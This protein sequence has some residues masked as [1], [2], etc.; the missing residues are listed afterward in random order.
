MH[1]LNDSIAPFRARVMAILPR[2]VV[3]SFLA[4]TGAD[5]DLFG[6][7]TFGREIVHAFN[8]HR[9][10]PY[11][12]TSDISWVNHEW[13]AEA[14]MW[15]AYAAGGAPGLVALKLLLAAIAGALMLATWK[16]YGLRLVPREGLLFVVALAAWPQFVSAR[17]QM[18]SLTA[19]AWL[20]YELERFR[21]GSD[22]GLWRLPMLFAIWVNLH[23]GW[24][25]GAGV[26]ILFTVVTLL[27]GT[28]AAG[29]RVRLV[30]AGMA[31]A[32]AT[33]INPYGPAMLGFLAD[34]VRPQRADILE[35]SPITALPP[36]IIVVMAVP[37]V[38]GA[39]A[40]WRGRHVI[41]RSSLVICVVLAVGALRVARLVGFC[42]MAVGFLLAPFLIVPRGE[43]P[44]S[45]AHP[46]RAPRA[47]AA[48]LT[49][50]AIVCAMIAL[51][52]ALFGRTITMDGEW[53]PEPDAVA[54][55]KEH[56]LSGR[57]LTWF[58]YGEYAIWHLWPEIRVS[59]DGRRETVYSEAIRRAHSTI[60]AGT[61]GAIDA[62]R[63]FDPDHAWLPVESP[64]IA[65]LEKAGWETVFK[66]PRSVV[67]TRT[68]L[69]GP[70]SEASKNLTP[71]AF[72]GP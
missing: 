8:V 66:G 65:Q 13:L 56:R 4:G 5:P 40:A 18:F 54:A 15:L 19:F 53:L 61:P 37:I 16:P 7:L 71:R 67:L 28:V 27:E 23:G 11:S 43:A 64:M 10:D 2:L 39:V 50:S 6:H 51:A 30:A 49:D 68:P 47:S 69:H 48:W 57:M 62:L 25:V 63:Q 46:I 59:N 21:R 34:T 70:P 44:S 20:L 31:S 1:R 58:N 38:L 42:G 9:S 45:A 60:Y 14:T 36:I 17:P 52:V 72:P 24:L 22:R 33:M 12:F 32:V 26:L 41:P 3:L 35:W 29:R 55:I